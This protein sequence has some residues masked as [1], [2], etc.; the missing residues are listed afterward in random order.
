MLRLLRDQLLKKRQTINGA[1]FIG[2]V[3]DGVPPMHCEKLAFDLKA[4]RNI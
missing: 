3:V 4:K 2:A 1:T